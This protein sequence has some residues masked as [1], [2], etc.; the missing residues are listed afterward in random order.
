MNRYIALGCLGLGLMVSPLLGGI[1]NSAVPANPK[2]GIINFGETILNTPAGR[3][4]AEAFD[5]T[6]K[7]KQGLLDK[8]QEELKKA[9]ADLVKQKAILKPE[10]FESKR[11]ELEKKFV[12]LQQTY[13]KLE[14]ELAQDQKKLQEELEAQAKPKI[15][16]LAKAEGVTVILDASA[17]LW[18]DP[19]V[20][21]TQK[22]NAEMK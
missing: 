15:L 21:L 6:R 14:R 22:L 8:Q 13:L 10:V 3:R 2:I 11:Q 19:A 12:E 4:A 9:D 17:A 7:T 5:K 1:G 20:D 18:A 16:A